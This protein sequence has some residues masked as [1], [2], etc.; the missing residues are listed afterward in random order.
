VGLEIRLE[1]VA[2]LVAWCG[3]AV[4]AERYAAVEM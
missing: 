3:V 1:V 4:L 2:E